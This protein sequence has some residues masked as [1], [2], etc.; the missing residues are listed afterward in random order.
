MKG[1]DI[2]L[3][4]QLVFCFFCE[5][6]INEMTKI[7]C[8]DCGDIFLCVKCF[9]EGK[10]SHKY[11]NSHRYQVYDRLDFKLFGDNWTA[12]EELIL[13]DGLYQFGY[14]NW[15]AISKHIGTDKT[16]EETERHF[17]QVYLDDDRSLESKTRNQPIHE[18]SKSF[19]IFF[20][21]F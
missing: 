11:K 7:F 16:M 21:L 8:T 19:H 18:E 2:S 15:K 4:K 5:R 1:D 6:K 12:R 9:A 17:H 3:A 10:E 13:L 20:Y 14:G